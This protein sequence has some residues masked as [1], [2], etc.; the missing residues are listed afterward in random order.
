MQEISN[1]GSYYQLCI[2][3]MPGNMVRDTSVGQNR[4]TVVMKDD[5]PSSRNVV[6]ESD[7]AF[8]FHMVLV[9]LGCL[10]LLTFISR[11]AEK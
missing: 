8:K 2:Q 1:A 7:D 9:L 6:Y 11:G 4:A 3:V 5:R 10:L